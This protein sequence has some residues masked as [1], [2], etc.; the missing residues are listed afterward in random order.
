MPDYQKGKIYKL[1]SPQG[2]EIYIGSTINTLAKRLGNHKICHNTCNSKYLFENYDDVRIE[3]IEEYPCNNKME[4]DRKEGQHIRNNECLN[5]RIAGRTQKEYREDNKEDR[6]EYNKKWCQDNKEH[7]KEYNKKWHE[8]NKEHEQ[9][10][11]EKNKERLSQKFNCECGIV[12]RI[13]DKARHLKSKKHIA[14]TNS[15]QE[16]QLLA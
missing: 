12:I 9:K 10:Y 16:Q 13:G 8:N 14:F 3:L 2:N 15:Q 4:L 5:T 6:Q 1:W 7:K 11:R